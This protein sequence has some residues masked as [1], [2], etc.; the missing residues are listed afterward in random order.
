MA[1]KSI[2]LFCVFFGCLMYLACQQPNTN[3]S[4][5]MVEL[6][7]GS[8]IAKPSLCLIGDSPAYSDASVIHY[9]EAGYEALKNLYASFGI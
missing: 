4:D 3:N 1:K 9:N 5:S 7:E 6:R 8:L 2:V